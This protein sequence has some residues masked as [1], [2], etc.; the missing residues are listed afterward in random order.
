LNEALEAY[1]N[2]LKYNAKEEGLKERV[3]KKIIKLK[4]KQQN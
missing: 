4:K 3:E 2:S 1:T